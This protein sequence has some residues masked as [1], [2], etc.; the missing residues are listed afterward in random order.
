MQFKLSNDII[1]INEK[2]TNFLNKLCKSRNIIGNLKITVPIFFKVFESYI[3]S[4]FV[5]GNI[6]MGY[7]IA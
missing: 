3:A 1:L 7:G 4:I 2:P 5:Y 6:G